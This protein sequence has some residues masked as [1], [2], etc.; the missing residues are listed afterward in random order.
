LDADFASRFDSISGRI[1]P[2]FTTF[3]RDRFR[4]FCY[5]F[6]EFSEGFSRMLQQAELERPNPSDWQVR[7]EHWM[8]HSANIA[9]VSKRKK[10]ERNTVPLILC[11]HG[12]SLRIRHGALVIRDGFTH[13][14]QQQKTYCFFPRDLDLPPRIILLDGSGSISFDVL[15]W[16]SQQGVSLARVSWTGDVAAVASGCGYAGDQDKL[17]WQQETRSDQNRRFAFAT[18][19]IRHKL[20]ASQRTLEE[21]VPSSAA[22]DIALSKASSAI[23]RLGRE[24]FSDMNYIFAIEGECAS[25]YFAAWRGMKLQWKGLSRRPVPEGWL[26]YSGRS[27]FANVGRKENRNASHPVNAILNYAY[28]VKLA[29]LQMQCIADGYDPTIGIMHASE[30]GKPAFLLDLI[31]PERPNVD[32]EVLR[33]IRQQPLASADFII[34]PNGSCRL[35]PQFARTVATLV[36]TRS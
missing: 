36:L 34:R 33:L 26:A 9:T 11:G 24:S 20:I 10:R 18:D 4:S 16:L 32:A 21:Q 12:V 2:F 5:I 15:T 7:G 25:A 14:P 23:E 6:S 8:R 19:L 17:R 22:R 35:S 28:A 29:A 30:P 3:S 13:Y 27:S 1:S 31:E